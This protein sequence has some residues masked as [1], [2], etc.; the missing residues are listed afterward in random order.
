MHI[1]NSLLPILTVIALGAILRRRN[2][3]GAE[4]TQGFNAFAYFWALPLFLFYKLGS[5][6]TGIGAANA[7]LTTLMLATM[8]SLLVG[9]LVSW[10]LQLSVASRG[11]FVQACFRGN[12]AFIGLPLVLFSL[13]AETPERQQQIEAAVLIALAPTVIFYNVAAVTLLAI[14][15]HRTAV[16]FSWKLIAR[17]IVFNPILVSC[18][19]GFTFQKTGWEI[20]TS[21]ER[22]CIIVGAAAFPMALLGIGSQMATLEFSGRWLEPLYTS[23]IKSIVCPV[24]GWVVGRAMGLEGNE[25]RVILILCAMPPAVSGYVLVDQMKGDSDLA[26]GTVVVGTAF[27][28]LPLVVLLG[29]TF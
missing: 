2:F 27:C 25:L 20:P 13:A 3:L 1:I 26:A 8:G 11:A 28:L 18:V 9:W 15:N 23:L 14:Y 10:G 12:L 24:L 29:L 21:I 7:F 4:T 19:A 17:N 6:T 16:L 5:A 22:T